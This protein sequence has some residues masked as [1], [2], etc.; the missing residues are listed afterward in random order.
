MGNNKALMAIGAHLSPHDHS[1]HQLATQ[2]VP[3]DEK[4]LHAEVWSELVVELPADEIWAVY[5]SH[6]LPRLIVELLPQ[7]FDKIDIV[8][9]DGGVGT[10]MYC[11]LNPANSGPQTW[12]EKIIKMDDKTR[13]KVVRQIEGGYL[14]IGFHMYE[15]IFTITPK[16][17]NSCIIRM[18]ASFDV[19][20]NSASNASL[21]SANW[22][23]GKAIANYVFQN[24]A[25]KHNN[26]HGN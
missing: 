19:D 5:S 3:Y 17:A 24:K 1:K 22:S 26:A 2:S 20:D 14:G 16:D 7:R 9:G 4:K 25:N 8:E 10:I 18:T 21:I 6:D 13:T 12:K 15:H 23:M 11:V